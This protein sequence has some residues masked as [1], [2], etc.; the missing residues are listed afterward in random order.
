MAS[1][2]HLVFATP[3]LLEQI[4]LELPIR[5]L[6]MSRRVSRRWADTIKDSPKLHGMSTFRKPMPMFSTSSPKEVV[7]MNPKFPRQTNEPAHQALEDTK[8]E[9]LNSPSHVAINHKAL[10]EMDSDSRLE[11]ISQPPIQTLTIW[12][13]FAEANATSGDV[14][15][16]KGIVKTLGQ[17]TTFGTLADKLQ[18]FINKASEHPATLPGHQLVDYVWME[19]GDVEMDETC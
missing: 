14:T 19:L 2:A 7:T 6:I 1:A 8:K 18:N 9:N 11:L 3:E 10:F 15:W 5:G 12:W 13:I 17:G 4:L 16:F